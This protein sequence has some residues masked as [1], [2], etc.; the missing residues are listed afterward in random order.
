MRDET[1]AAHGFSPVR[2]RFRSHPYETA[3][4]PANTISRRLKPGNTSKQNAALLLHFPHLHS[5]QIRLACYGGSKQR[6]VC[7]RGN[8]RG[9]VSPSVV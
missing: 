3:T 2:P 6:L 8:H 7:A 9:I 5:S 4:L 1:R